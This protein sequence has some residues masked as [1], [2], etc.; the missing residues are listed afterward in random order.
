MREKPRALSETTEMLGDWLLPAENLREPKE[1]GGQP[2]VPQYSHPHAVSAHDA[3]DQP[4]S[5]AW[6]APQLFPQCLYLPRGTHYWKANMMCVL[7]KM[8]VNRKY[9]F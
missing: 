2:L 4:C 8:L 5:S 3:H 9:I 6:P 7:I 1:S